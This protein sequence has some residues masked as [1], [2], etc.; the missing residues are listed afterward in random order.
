M[1][2]IDGIFLTF[3]GLLIDQI[4]PYKP[5]NGQNL[6]ENPKNYT[7]I[8]DRRLLTVDFRPFNLCRKYTGVTLFAINKRNE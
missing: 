3:S 7:G 5:E 6:T 1:S 2:K 4:R 8:F